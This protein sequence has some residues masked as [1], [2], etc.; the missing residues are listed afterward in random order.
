MTL[1]VAGYEGDEIFFIGDSAITSDNVP[2]LSGFKKIYAVPIVVHAPYFLRTFKNYVPFRGYQGECVIALAG[3][4][5][6]AQHVINSV[7]G[8]L[9]KIRVKHDYDENGIKYSL[10]RHCNTRDNQLYG[11]AYTE[12]DD[13]VYLD[14]DIFN[15]ITIDNIKQII[16]YSIKEALSSASKYYQCEK[17]WGSVINN[18]YLF[19]LACPHTKQNFLYQVK[20]VEEKIEGGIKAV[21]EISEIPKGSIG[22]IGLKKFNSNINE[23]YQ[24]L[25]A[26]PSKISFGM[27][28]CIENIINACNAEGFKGIAKPIIYKRFNGKLVKALTINE[29]GSWWKLDVDETP[30]RVLDKEK[31]LHDFPKFKFGEIDF[32]F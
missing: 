32:K 26:T 7:V 12:Y 20:L 23:E 14:K 31:S 29:N 18:E 25:L 5:L 17:K 30:I 10:I 11:P 28:N 3:S 8:H 16:E 27:L 9:D 24:K 21:P 1:V 2:L 13:D 22:I 15:S 6:I 19:A 4:T